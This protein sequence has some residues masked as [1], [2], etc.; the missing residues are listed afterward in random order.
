VDLQALYRKALATRS[1]TAW[2]DETWSRLWDHAVLW[3]FLQEWLDLI[4]A[5]PEALLLT[6]AEQLDRV[7][8]DPVE[9]AARRRL[10]TSR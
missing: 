2:D 10:G 5:I 9:A 7:W 8:L 1:G 4:A 3:R 6:S